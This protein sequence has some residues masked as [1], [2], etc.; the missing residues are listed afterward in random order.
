M[1]H[2]NLVRN[3][4]EVRVRKLKKIEEKRLQTD[5]F[6]EHLR[7]S[8]KTRQKCTVWCSKLKTMYRSAKNE[9][10]RGIRI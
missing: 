5:K 2:H 9:K 4:K 6:V 10:I 1:E 3:L 7:N 8:R